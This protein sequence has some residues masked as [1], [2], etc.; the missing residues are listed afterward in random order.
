MFECT[1]CGACC[2]REGIVE[3]TADEA[4]SAARFML[5]PDASPADLGP[6]TWSRLA[7]GS[8]Q[9]AVPK[10]GGCAFLSADN[11]CVIQPVKPAQCATYPFW[12]SIVARPRP[13]LAESRACEGIGRGRTWTR[14][15]IDAALART[16]I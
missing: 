4:T 13:W 10:G 7:D 14:E 9:V 2:R 12:R 3:F 11:R 6:S 15:E 16:D 8:Y 5:G 1:G